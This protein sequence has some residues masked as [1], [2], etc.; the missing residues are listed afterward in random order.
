MIQIAFSFAHSGFRRLFGD[1]FMG[2]YF[3]PQFAG[4]SQLSGDHNSGGL[5][6]IAANKPV[7]QCLEAVLAKDQVLTGRGNAPILAP[8]GFS[9]LNSLGHH[10]H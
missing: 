1:G 9:I 2:E 10:N 4:P 5:D 3:N 7:L 6:L 8:L